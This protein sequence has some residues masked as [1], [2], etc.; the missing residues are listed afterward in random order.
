MEYGR[1][2]FM[3]TAGY[4]RAAEL[5]YPLCLRDKSSNQKQYTSISSV[6]EILLSP[7]I[8]LLLRTLSLLKPH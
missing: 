1:K 3:V 2:Y 8:S 5:H 4:Y 7:L 6:F